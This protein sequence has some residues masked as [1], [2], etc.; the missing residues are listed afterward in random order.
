MEAMELG[1][2]GELFNHLSAVM[3]RKDGSRSERDLFFDCLFVKETLPLT[4]D[5]SLPS[6]VLRIP[7]ALLSSHPH[8]KVK[9][10]DLVFVIRSNAFDDHDVLTIQA[11][12]SENGDQLAVH[13]DILP[14]CATD[15]D[16]EDTKGTTRLY[17]PRFLSISQESS[18][19]AKYLY[20]GD[21]FYGQIKDNQY[22]GLGLY[23]TKSQGIYLGLF[24]QNKQHG[25]GIHMRPASSE[26]DGTVP[27]AIYLGSFE[28]NR[29]HGEGIIRDSGGFFWEVQYEQGT[30]A[31]RQMAEQSVQLDAYEGEEDLP[32][33][34]IN[35]SA[36]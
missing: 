21:W 10:G 24:S 33:P 28:M 35:I 13:P 30:C 18:T 9:E 32:Y 3:Q 14:M 15:R 7:Q 27:F 31:N 22:H 8:W 11:R 25:R 6:D 20:E 16:K 5:E 1:E 36:V 4:A 17:L 12:M 29:R 19:I 34:L 23:Y 26:S 2:A